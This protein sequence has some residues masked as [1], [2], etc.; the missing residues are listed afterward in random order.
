MGRYGNI[1]L[2]VSVAFALQGCGEFVGKGDRT[3]DRRAVVALETRYPEATDVVWSGRESYDVAAFRLDGADLEAWLGTEGEWYMTVSD[4]PLSDLPGSV[5]T[6]LSTGSY[7]GWEAV[8]ADRID[9]EYAHTIYVV[10]MRLGET[11]RGLYFTPSGVLF[12]EEEDLSGDYRDCIPFESIGRIETWIENR[13]PGACLLDIERENGMTEVEILD[14]ALCRELFFDASGSW[15]R[16]RTDVDSPT[17]VL[18]MREMLTAMGDS[19]WRVR[20][21]DLHETP[22]ARFYRVELESSVG[23]RRRLDLEDV[24]PCVMLTCSGIQSAF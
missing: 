23:E 7:A 21:V 14:G 6:A 24:D 19:K 3:P 17:A 2:A 5:D 8:R 10:E 18:C 20:K 16:S 13:Y 15:V 9:R 4:L 1:V 22:T 12:R 11:C